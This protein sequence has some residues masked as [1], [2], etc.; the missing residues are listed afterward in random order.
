MCAPQL[1]AARD[2]AL[3]LLRRVDAR[4]GNEHL[5]NDPAQA[6]GHARANDEEEALYAKVQLP[7]AR[8]R[9]AA[10]HDADDTDYQHAKSKNHH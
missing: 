6:P 5:G 10:R 1:C 3:A 7:H 4:V 9:D 2:A 8:Q